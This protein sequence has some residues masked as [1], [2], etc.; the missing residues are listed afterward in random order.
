MKRL[1]CALTLALTMALTGCNPMARLDVKEA[2]AP[3]L[4]GMTVL[5]GEMTVE[6][7]NRKDIVVERAELVVRS[8]RREIARARLVSP[9]RMPGRRTTEVDYE[10]ELSSVSLSGV[11]ALMNRP[12][13]VTVDIDARMRIGSK[14]K[15]LKMD[16]VSLEQLMDKLDL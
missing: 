16:D 14:H 6:N 5:R 2:D 10:L 9:V 11:G 7:D 4:R 1:I 15:R 8:G 13:G 12:R 3:K